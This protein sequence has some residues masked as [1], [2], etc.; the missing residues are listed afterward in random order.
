M[1]YFS[2]L[3]LFLVSQAHAY[4]LQYPQ[5]RFSCSVEYRES[6]DISI[7]EGDEFPTFGGHLETPRVK[8]V[9]LIFDFSGMTEETATAYLENPQDLPNWVLVTKPFYEKQSAYMWEYE[10]TLNYEINWNSTWYFGSKIT[11]TTKT[12]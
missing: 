12:F 3:F 7:G 4:E 11:L 5:G 8:N 10:N 1:R 2:L 6:F 9:D